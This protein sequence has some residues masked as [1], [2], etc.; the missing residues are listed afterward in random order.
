MAF[1]AEMSSPHPSVPPHRVDFDM[2]MDEVVDEVFAE[3]A[4]EFAGAVVA[5]VGGAVEAEHALAGEALAVRGRG[6]EHG[7]LQRA[8]D[9]P[10]RE[11][12]AQEMVRRAVGAGGDFLRGLG[13][14][15]R[16]GMVRDEHGIE[17]GIGQVL[18]GDAGHGDGEVGAREPALPQEDFAGGEAHG[19]LRGRV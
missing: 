7:E 5:A 15:L 6:D 18:I 16:G 12:A 1:Q 19:A 11:G 3:E 9:A 14:E 13:G 2:E 8:A 10:E 4:E 17:R